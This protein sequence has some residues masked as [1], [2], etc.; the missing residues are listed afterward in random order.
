MPMDVLRANL[1]LDYTDRTP[2]DV[3]NANPAGSFPNGT[4]DVPVFLYTSLQTLLLGTNQYSGVYQAQFGKQVI[5]WYGRGETQATTPTIELQATEY[6][7]HMSPNFPIPNMND[8]NAVAAKV[9]ILFRQPAPV[10]P[11]NY[12]LVKNIMLRT[13]Y[14]LDYP[15]RQKRGQPADL[16]VSGDPSVDATAGWFKCF[17]DSYLKV[18]DEIEAAV[19]YTVVFKRKLAYF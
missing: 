5:S 19:Q 7:T 8:P 3:I 17:F 6:D 2:T 11:A 12:G 9:Q 1:L 13:Q 4:S 16:P 18:P 14:L 10:N 15:T